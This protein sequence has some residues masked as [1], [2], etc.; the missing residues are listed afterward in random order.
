MQ[1]LQALEPFVN[2]FQLSTLSV[3]SEFIIVVVVIVV[4]SVAINVYLDAQHVAEN[5]EAQKM[6]L[7]RTKVFVDK[8]M[9]EK[10]LRPIEASNLALKQGELVY[11]QSA[12]VLMETRSVRHYHS[13][14]G[15]VRVAK[16]VYIGGSKG[17]SESMD[18]WKEIDRGKIHVTNHR[19]VFN[20]MNQHRNLDL[21]KIVSFEQFARDGVKVAVENRQKAMIFVVDDP[22]IM[23]VVGM[24]C[25]N[26]TDLDALE[27]DKMD[28][29]F[30]CLTTNFGE[31]PPP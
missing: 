30:S 25:M 31:T 8:V 28:F 15:A 22:G 9:T 7:L 27:T 12:A 26:A 29:D 2:S 18:A 24:I 13:G 17:Q 14:G 4:I 5:K 11:F 19:I 21:K 23:I 6:M 10:R 3:M 16:G 20:G 1:G